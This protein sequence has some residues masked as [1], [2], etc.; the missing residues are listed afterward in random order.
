MPVYS[1]FV[2][3]IDQKTRLLRLQ[4]VL[5]NLAQTLSTKLTSEMPPITFHSSIGL[6]MTRQKVQQPTAAAGFIRL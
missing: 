1:D 2:N 3:E 4:R 5:H 6:R